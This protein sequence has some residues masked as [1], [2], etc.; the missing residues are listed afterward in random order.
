MPKEKLK[1][2]EL[3]KWG[4]TFGKPDMER[5]G[6][7]AEMPYMNGKGY[8]SP[9]A[10]RNSHMQIYYKINER[11]ILVEKSKNLKGFICPGHKIVCGTQDGLF[12]SEFK[13]IFEKEV[14][15]RGKK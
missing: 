15:V 9:F 12:E 1:P 11:T 7:F 10:G 8:V 6:L 2:V 3:T 4:F 14:I 13:R 5:I